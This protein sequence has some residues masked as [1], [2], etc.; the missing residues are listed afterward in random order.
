MGMLGKPRSL[1]MQLPR[2]LFMPPFA[3]QEMVRTVHSTPLLFDKTTKRNAEEEDKEEMERERQLRERFSQKIVQAMP[4][5]S[6]Q[7]AGNCSGGTCGPT[8]PEATKQMGR[9]LFFTFAL[10]T[11]LL[12]SQL[13]DV[14]S[15]INIMKNI[16]WWQLPPSSVA[17]YMLLRTLLP[18]KEQ[19]RL[20]EE[21]ETLSRLNPKL[22]FDQFFVQH[23]PDVFHGYRTQQQD[24]VAAVAACVVFAN[25]NS[26][27]SMTIA[28]AAGSARDIRASVDNIMEA[29]RRQYPNVFQST[30]PQTP[31]LTVSQ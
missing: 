8:P 27:L 3:L 22:T 26:N 9:L 19:K 15:P 17:Y 25:N 20:K 6:S 16:P 28:R 29:L 5:Y 21:Y 12:L 1:V 31:T 14:D 24:I 2:R 11:L 18:F 30:V 13:A 23:Y 10:M 7:Q 4:Q